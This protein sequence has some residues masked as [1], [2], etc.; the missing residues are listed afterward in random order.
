MEA[1]GL[2]LTSEQLAAADS[3]AARGS[4]LVVLAAMTPQQPDQLM[5][6][7][8][9]ATRR[10]DVPLT[11]MFAD[12]GGAFAF[13][14][15]P[16]RVEIASGR[17]R[18][19][20]LAG[21]IPGRWSRATDYLPYSL[22]D[23]DRMLGDGT[24]HID[25]VLARVHRSARP[26]CFEYGD[27]VG[28]TA[29]GLS[30][31]AVAILEVTD[32][33]PSSRGAEAPLIPNGRAAVVLGSNASA[34]LG[35]PA[36]PLSAAQETIGR[37]VASLIPDEATVQLGLGSVVEAVVQSLSEKRDLGLHSGVL[38][39]SLS[40][41]VAR[42]VVTGRAKS[43]D[44]GKAV[45]TGV[46]GATTEAPLSWHGALE[47]RPI[48]RTHDPRALARHDRL[49]AVNSAL[50]VDLRGQ[51]NAEFA[52]GMRVASGG[53]QTDF[54][55]SAH[56]SQ[57]GGS[58]IALPS[59]TSR[60][61]SR[62]VARFPSQ[63]PATSAGQDV[64]FVVTEHGAA[65]L[66]GLTAHERATALIAIADP[67]SRDCLHRQWREQDETTSGEPQALTMGAR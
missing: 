47:L 38:T 26:G 58:I 51:V 39:P 2:K 49:W 7:F 28:Y 16:M 45:A 1:T 57:G 23:I 20:S 48:S 31:D 22:W 54:I 10:R 40:R 65:A 36:A 34:K 13:L 37:H 43:E 21:S 29:V 50:E 14:D 44:K 33:L 35:A 12:L 56:L 63:Y 5:S 24:L 46:F 60:G 30:T 18:L 9:L 3:L 25:V 19:V 8:V 27:M 53:G 62:I 67:A 66:R 32:A 52:L 6:A 41:L 4:P 42:G 55:R 11:L 59:R 61:D 17:L 64:D 15:E